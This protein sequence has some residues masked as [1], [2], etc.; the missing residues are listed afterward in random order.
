[1]CMACHVVNRSED[2]MGKCEWCQKPME[3]TVHWKRFCC[4][5]CRGSWHKQERHVAILSFRQSGQKLSLP[6]TLVDQNRQDEPETGGASLG[7]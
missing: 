2:T 6:D 7:T 4:K 5:D 1:M 3:Q